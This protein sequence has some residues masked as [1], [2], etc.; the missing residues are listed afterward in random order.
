L[1]H[2]QLG[3]QY[4]E[5]KRSKLRGLSVSILSREKRR[6]FRGKN[7]GKRRV[8]GLVPEGRRNEVKDTEEQNNEREEGFSM[9]K[10]KNE[11]TV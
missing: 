8:E 11:R 2:N 1:L 7:I 5:R 6:F 10:E 9:M 4:F 3:F